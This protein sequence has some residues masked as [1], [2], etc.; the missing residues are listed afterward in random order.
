MH[1]LKVNYSR[2]LKLELP[3]LAERVV[4]VFETYDPEEYKIKEAY[5]QLVA[6]Q[7]Q[8]DA[9]LAQYGEHPLT[10][11][12]YRLRKKRARYA[13]EI[14]SQMRFHRKED[15]ENK[16]VISA[17]LISDQFLLH[18]G[19]NNEEV[20]NRRITQFFAEIQRNEGLATILDTL[21]LLGRCE[22]LQLVHTEIQDLLGKRVLSMAA[23]PKGKTMEFAKSI[24]KA[25]KVLFMQIE[26]SHTIHEDLDYLP[27]IDTLNEIMV[28]YRNLINSRATYNKKKKEGL[29][30]E[31]TGETDAGDMPEIL[32]T[33]VEPTNKI[34]FLKVEEISENGCDGELNELLAKKK[35]VVPS[36]KLVQL[37]SVNNEAQ[38]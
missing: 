6:R 32:T 25:L 30:N 34:E 1:I 28:R 8:I 9:L 27:I 33:Y 24:R 14:T 2:L 29:E 16:E 31:A 5:D 12:L 35:T 21:E 23:R 36:S 17:K 15:I 4:G 13:A 3:E 10:V 26:V 22:K 20:I 19:Q 7:P 11:T 18:L 38:H 37:P